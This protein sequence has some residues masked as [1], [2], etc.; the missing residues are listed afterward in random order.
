MRMKNYLKQFKC[1]YIKGIF[2]FLIIILTG[3]N[4]MSR[5]HDTDDPHPIENQMEEAHAQASESSDNQQT[6]QQQQEAE[7]QQQNA[8]EYKQQ[9]ELDAQQQAEPAETPEQP[10]S[11]QPLTIDFAAVAPSTQ[12]TYEELVCDSGLDE[13]IDQA[14]PAGTYTLEVDVINNV[15]IAFDSASGEIVRI[16]RC[17]TGERG[18]S[19]PQGSYKIGSRKERFGYFEEFDC[20]AQYWTQVHEG[21]FFHSIL[22]RE[23]NA[24]TL[25]RSS[26]RNLGKSTSHGCIR[27]TVPD[28]RW[29][30]ENIA[31]G[32][33]I[34]II[35][36]PK[37][38]A[39]IA[40]L[41]LPDQT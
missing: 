7:M 25:I 39:L 41:K 38:E 6:G 34:S 5:L 3:C 24:S 8:L 20:Y 36:K 23:R 18:T 11:V 28:A 31:P 27:L 29:I 32:T 21:I 16:M 15:T 37:D 19:T 1:T 40:A 13:P 26:Y 12:M 22:Y 35:E 10:S 30:Y 9:T 33:P 2:L 17:T 4:D 14:P